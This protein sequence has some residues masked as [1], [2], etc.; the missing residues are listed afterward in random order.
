MDTRKH[1]NRKNQSNLLQLIEKTSQ[2][3]LVKF[4]K[5]QTLHK[6]KH[7]TASLEV[8]W[9]VWK[10]SRRLFGIPKFKAGKVKYKRE[11]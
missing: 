6:F 7:I 3:N 8:I 4:T 5:D 1:N 2:E 9:K 11:I 10:S